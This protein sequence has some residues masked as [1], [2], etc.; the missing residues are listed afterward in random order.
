MYITSLSLEDVRIIKS[1]DLSFDQG[2]TAFVGDNGQG[3]TSLLEAMFWTSHAKSFRHVSNDDVIRKDCDFAKI[4]LHLTDGQR[5]QDIVA[6]INRV[7]R[8]GVFVNG[9]RLKRNRDLAT[10][11]RVSVFTPDDLEIIKGSSSFRREILDDALHQISP[12]YVAAYSDYQRT[13][14]QKNA[15]L[16]DQHV[17]FSVLDVLNTSLA[18]SGAQVLKSRLNA[19]STMR[20]TLQSSYRHIA[21]DEPVVGVR[22]ISKIFGNDHWEDIDPDEDQN[23]EALQE[24]FL[25]K[26]NYYKDIELRRAHSVVGPHRD[27]LF[28]AIDDRDTRTQASQGEQRTMALALKMALHHVV[29]N[30]TGDNPVLLL[31]DVFS[32]LDLGRTHRLVESLPSAQTFVTTATELPST[33]KVDK[34]FQVKNGEISSSS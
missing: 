22:Y 24:L 13:L 19:L 8:A 15:L 18:V 23:V 11:L 21:D 20:E 32:E 31:D 4:E 30:A 2:V 6:T 1:C 34:I 17:D 10:T 27:D 14:K 7:G 12:K 16:K 9:Q 28:L 3:K 29:H 33:L 25:E 5:P 26:I